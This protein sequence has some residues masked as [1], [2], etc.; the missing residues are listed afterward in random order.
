MYNNEK[1]GHTAGTISIPPSITPMLEGNVS[2]LFNYLNEQESLIRQV[3]T[4]LH[5]IVDKN[6]PEKEQEN[7]KP[8]LIDID[9]Q[10]REQLNHLN[11]NN[12]M[13]Q[14][15]LNHLSEII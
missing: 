11:H 12:L 5:K 3:Q 7:T 13:L 10:F 15:I 1:Q 6:R 14:N 8:I 2:T 9:Q 4:K